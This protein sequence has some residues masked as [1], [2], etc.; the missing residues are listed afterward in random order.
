MNDALIIFL[1]ILGAGAALLVGYAS[2]RF[3]TPT[4]P[5]EVVDEPVHDGVT[6]A[7]YMRAVRQRN[8]EQLEA[9][10]LKP[11]PYVGEAQSSLTPSGATSLTR[12]G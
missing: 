9:L 7:Q 6:Q 1:C 8:Q 12:E 5:K 2:L 4:D 11:R 10:S 3:F